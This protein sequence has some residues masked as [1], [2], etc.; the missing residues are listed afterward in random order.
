MVKNPAIR[1]FGTLCNSG[2]GRHENEDGDDHKDDNDNDNNDYN[3]VCKQP[4]LALSLSANYNI[5]SPGLLFKKL[6][7][8][9]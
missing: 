3:E 8:I 9:I 5:L 2:G 1:Q 7:K 6:S 4:P